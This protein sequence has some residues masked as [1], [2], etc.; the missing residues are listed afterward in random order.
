MQGCWWNAILDGCSACIGYKCDEWEIRIG[1]GCWMGGIGILILRMNILLGLIGMSGPP[2]SHPIGALVRRTASH[3]SHILRSR[4]DGM[5]EWTLKLT[6]WQWFDKADDQ[7]RI[8]WIVQV[9][10]DNC[11]SPLDNL[12]PRFDRPWVSLCRRAS[13]RNSRQSSFL[14]G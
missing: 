3:C 9:R 6:F 10:A 1:I 14:P 2:S 13:H 11:S 12:G 8:I 5:K 4:W 7:L